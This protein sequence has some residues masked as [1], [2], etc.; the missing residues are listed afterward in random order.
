M[1]LPAPKA[2]LLNLMTTGLTAAI[3]LDEVGQ[4]KKSEK[5][6]ITAAAGGVGHLAVQWA[7]ARGC[8][9]V[10]TCSSETKAK[11]LEQLGCDHV[12]N[13]A[14]GDLKAEIAKTYPVR[15][16]GHK[17]RPLITI[18]TELQDG[19]DVIWDTV[20][21][22]MTPMFVNSLATKGRLVLIGAIAGYAN[23]GT[24][25]FPAF[26]M[27]DL[28]L[29]LLSRSRAMAGF[30][31]PDYSKLYKEYMFKL[32]KLYTDGQLKLVIDDGSTSG[33]GKFTGLDGVIRAVEVSCVLN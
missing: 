26:K 6:L 18:Y 13:Y 28:P 31:L 27:A 29:K 32:L 19:L 30:F 17:A 22:E 1:P 7:K 11:K 2:E 8:H 16:S 24:S 12:I 20:G 25:G 4:I 9:V 3:G 15:T 10:G 21:G 33:G 14:S 23:D 5:V